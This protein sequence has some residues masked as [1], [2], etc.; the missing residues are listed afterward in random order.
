MA[1]EDFIQVGDHRSGTG[2]QPL[3]ETPIEFP[4]ESMSAFNRL[5]V[6]PPYTLADMINHYEL[7]LN[8][9]VVTTVGGGDVVHLP[10]ESALEL[11]I[12]GT[13]GDLAGLRTRDYFRYQAGKSLDW[14]MT[15]VHGDTG[16]ANQTRRWGFVDAANGLFYRLAG[17]TVAVVTRSS[18]SGSVT[19][20]AVPQAQWNVDKLDGTGPSGKTLDI[21][22]GNIYEARLQWLGVGVVRWFIN[23]VLVHV[24]EHA[25]LLPTPYMG[26]AQLPL[27]W[28][29]ENVA[30]SAPGAMKYICSR[31]NC[32]G[33]SD[34]PE[35]SFGYLMPAAISCPQVGETYLFSIRPK[36]TYP[37]DPGPDNHMVIIP[38]LAAFQAE[39]ARAGVRLV[40]NAAL[41][42]PVWASVD[43]Y[44]GVEIDEAATAFVGGQF[45]TRFFIPSNTGDNVNL[46]PYF[47][48]NGRRLRGPGM[49]MGGDVLTIVAQS[50][51]AAAAD[52]RGSLAWRE[53]R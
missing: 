37:T 35:Y 7:D 13:N 24:D 1:T 3:R 38:V 48:R 31:V 28:E 26:T 40:W 51:Q 19:E 52:V 44:S 16:H 45:V 12:G 23:Q 53:I 30:A 21:T 41:T 20:T 39:G 34:P 9:Y 50:E 22:K 33:G 42:A 4:I 27:A 15:I 25:G 49:D 2:A 11:S 5:R 14:L 47:R 10:N 36:P 46:D 8:E 17:T 29:I 6:D 43:G 32:D 18:T